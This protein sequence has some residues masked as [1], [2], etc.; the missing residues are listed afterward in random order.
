MY[1]RSLYILLMNS[2]ELIKG[3]LITITLKRLAD[4]RK[5]YGYE[6]T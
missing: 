3:T 2:S 6:I 1:G 4:E 5:R